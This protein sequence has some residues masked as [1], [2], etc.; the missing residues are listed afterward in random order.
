MLVDNDAVSCSERALVF[1]NFAGEVFDA[2]AT[3]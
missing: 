1:G 3:Y 2:V